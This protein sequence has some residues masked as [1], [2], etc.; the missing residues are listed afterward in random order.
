MLRMKLKAIKLDADFRKSEMTNYDALRKSRRF[1]GELKKNEVYLMVSKSGNQLVWI[2][3]TAQVSV[4]GHSDAV[5]EV[6]DS[7]RW[8]LRS[9][10]WSPH[11]LENYANAV[12][13]SLSGFKRLEDAYSR[14]K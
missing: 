13:I 8:R 9:G 3:N 1:P 11:M 2:L 6:V 10:T 7:R 14:R 12:G 4:N 5:C